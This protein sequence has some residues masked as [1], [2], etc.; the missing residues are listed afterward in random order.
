[1]KTPMRKAKIEDWVNKTEI[2]FTFIRAPG[3]GGQNVNKVASAVLLR[4]DLVSSSLPEN[5]RARLFSLIGKKISSEGEIIIKAT[6]YRTQERN[7]QDALERLLELINRAAIP[8]KK[9]K[10]TKPTRA[11]IQRRLA[12]KKLHG[13][14]KSLRKIK[15]Y[16]S[17]PTL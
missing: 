10:K 7:K 5:V 9:R 13:K 11:S 2:K 15:K 16:I 17:D 12:T 1:M 4:Y 14:N 8:V 3:P 6:R